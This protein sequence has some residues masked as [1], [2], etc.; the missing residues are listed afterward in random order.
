MGFLENVKEFR[1]MLE[2]S[3]DDVIQHKTNLTTEQILENFLKDL[4]EIINQEDELATE[5]ELEEINLDEEDEVEKF[6]NEVFPKMR[7]YT[8]IARGSRSNL[9]YLVWEGSQCYIVTYI[10]DTLRLIGQEF[11]DGLP[12][13]FWKMY[14]MFHYFLDGYHYNAHVY[15][16]LAPEPKGDDSDHVQ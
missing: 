12:D 15:K 14:R 5:R 4:D 8:E 1:E 6:L 11:F 10:Y 16:A 9:V 2:S 13:D 7:K 3:I